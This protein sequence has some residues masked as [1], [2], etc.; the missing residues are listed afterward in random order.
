VQPRKIATPAKKVYEFREPSNSI[1]ENAALVANG[2]T[3]GNA[4]G[5]LNVN[6]GRCRLNRLS[7]DALGDALEVELN[8]PQ[9]RA[10]FAEEGID[11][12]ILVALA[13][14]DKTFDDVLKEDLGMASALHRGKLKAW[15][16]KNMKA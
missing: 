11:G 14:D 3:G 13:L 7:S 16:A 4:L 2:S 1:A 10:I 15:V 5:V 9:Y 12:P 8:L 6:V